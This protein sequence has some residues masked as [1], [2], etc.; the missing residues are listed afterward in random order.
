[1][2][3]NINGHNAQ[4]EALPKIEKHSLITLQIRA[5][6]DARASN[7]LVTIQTGSKK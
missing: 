1:M 5:N 4:G 6:F 7:M 3:I 2:T